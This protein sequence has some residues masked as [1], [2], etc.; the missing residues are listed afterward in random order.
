MPQSRPTLDQQRSN[1]AFSDSRSSPP[2]GSKEGKHLR[3]AYTNAAKRLWQLSPDWEVNLL[4]N[5]FGPERMGSIAAAFDPL[6]KFRIGG[7]KVDVVRRKR[8]RGT[9]E[10]EV[11]YVAHARTEFYQNYVINPDFSMTIVPEYLVTVN[12]DEDVSLDLPSAQARRT[13]FTED[14]TD[15]LRAKEC[16][17]SEFRENN[18]HELRYTSA[19]G[20]T[21]ICRNSETTQYDDGR[22]DR[23][24]YITEFSYHGSGPIVPFVGNMGFDD[25]MQAQE[26]AVRMWC[27]ER[28]EDVLPPCLTSFREFNAFYQIGELKDLP[29]MIEKTFQTAHF[30]RDLV[31]NNPKISL[32]RTGKASGDAYLNEKFGYESMEQAAKSLMKTPERVAKRFN[33]LLERNSKVS[34]QR[35]KK[36]YR[37]PSLMGTFAPSWTYL[38]PTTVH[39]TVD[40]L[41]YESKPTAELRCV[42]NAIVN[43]PP[44]A[45]P[46]F[47]DSTY[48]DMIGLTPRLTDLYNLVPW[49]WLGDWFIG[50]SKYLNLIETVALDDSLVNVGFMTALVHNE[51]RVKGKLRLW[52]DYS[53]VRSEYGDT[54]SEDMDNPID[55]LFDTSGS[56]DYRTR[57]SIDEL[58]SVKSVLDKQSLLSGEQK[59]ILG[60]LLTK[61]F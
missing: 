38:V 51:A 37:N 27:A 13:T 57:F 58:P 4:M 40:D 53:I 47:S 60:A 50:V 34:S 10:Y 55:V 5:V 15:R 14:S 22:Y 30:L 48:R 39:Y 35:F 43:F 28:L 49:T 33:Y 7:Q 52:Q 29:M 9:Y 2:V 25:G 17:Y 19:P 56:M 11:G 32:R 31:T 12:P 18:P 8:V 46:K 45:V 61:F 24:K 36:E 41:V 44:L 26:D 21:F 54:I 6:F 59:S 42:V 16:R 20:G 3:G 23:I 1:V